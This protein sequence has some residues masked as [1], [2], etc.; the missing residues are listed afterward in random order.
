MTAAGAAA[1]IAGGSATAGDYGKAI[2]DDKMPIEADPWSICDIFDYSTLYEGEGFIKEISLTGR[3]HGQAISQSEDYGGLQN[4]YHEWQHRRARVGLDVEFANNVTFYSSINVSD[5]SGGGPFTKGVFFDTWDEFG[6][7]WEPSDDFYINLGKQKQKITVENATSSKRILTVERSTI[8]NE[9]ISDKPWG[10]TVGFVLGGIEHEVGGWMY[11][12]DLDS[13]GER[14]DWPDADS[15]GG[16]TYRGSFD[17]SDATE[18]MYGYQFTNNSSG[19]AGGNGAGTADSGLGSAYEHVMH[20]GSKSEWGNFGLITD[21][22]YAANREATGP[23]SAGN[24]TGGVVILPYYNITDKLQAV[25]KYAYMGDGR[26]QRTQRY[27]I[28]QRVDN[29]HTFYAGLN[30]YICGDKL[31]IMGGYEYATS[32]E[33]GTGVDIDS[34]TWMFAV[35]TY[36]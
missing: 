16:F 9:V 1:L 30:Y 32:E 6:I 31:K 36:W 23:I 27:D 22:I 12:A 4:G 20:V 33:Y 25:A 15:R 2:I 14:W 19:F 26:Q 13:T 28:R 29:M 11:G 18:I 5:G 35:R 34:S 10:V 8:V 24:D 7:E 17:I 3:Y 21:L